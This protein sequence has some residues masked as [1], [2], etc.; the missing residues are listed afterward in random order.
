[1]TMV[2]MEAVVTV[3]ATEVAEEGTNTSKL[4][5]KWIYFVGLLLITVIPYACSTL[6]LLWYLGPW[7]MQIAVALFVAITTSPPSR[8]FRP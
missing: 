8:P 1:M 2:T 7:R 5:G 3:V 6:F 4:H